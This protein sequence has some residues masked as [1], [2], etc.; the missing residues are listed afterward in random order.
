MSPPRYTRLTSTNVV[1]Q[2][3]VSEDSRY[4]LLPILEKSSRI[5][6]WVVYDAIDGE[7]YTKDDDPF[8]TQ[9]E[10]RDWV[11]QTHYPEMLS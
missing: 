4:V 9:F 11:N 2:V 3:H 8:P 6:G 5:T 7:V 10:A 1:F